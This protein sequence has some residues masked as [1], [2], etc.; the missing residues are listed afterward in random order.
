MEIFF[1]EIKRSP[2]EE[3]GSQYQF[4]GNISS[5]G[6][7]SV[8]KAIDINTKEEVAIKIINKSSHSI[9][10]LRIKEEINIL[11][12]LNHPNIL[13]FYDYIE[14]NVKVYI[15]ME[16]LKGGTLK[17]WINEHKNENISEETLSLIIKNILLAVSYLHNKNMC[18]R[19]IKPENI[20]FKDNSDINS[21]KLVD[22]GLSV[23][24]FDDYGEQTYCGTFIYMAPEQLENT[25]YSKIIDIWSIGIILYE[26]LNKGE[27]PFYIRGITKKNELIQ[28][29]KKHDLRCK[30]NVSIMG[31]NLIRKMLENQPT[32]RISANDALKHPW[33]TRN[34]LSPIP[35]NLYQKMFKVEIY[36]KSL[37]LVYIIVFLNYI[38]KKNKKNV[39]IIN[40]DYIQNVIKE[41]EIHKKNFFKRRLKEFKNFEDKKNDSPNFN[42]KIH[43]DEI[44]HFR[45]FNNKQR[46]NYSI[47]KTLN[48]YHINIMNLTSKHSFYNNSNSLKTKYYKK[49]VTKG[50]SKT[51][52]QLKMEKIPNKIA[53]KFLKNDLYDV[54]KRNSVKNLSLKKISS[55]SLPTIDNNQSYRNYPFSLNI[56]KLIL[57]K[58]KPLENNDKAKVSLFKLYNNNKNYF[59]N[60]K[61]NFKSSSFENFVNSK[62][63]TNDN[64]KNFEK[65]E[66]K[67]LSSSKLINHVNQKIETNN[68]LK[69][70]EKHK[71]FFFKKKK[72]KLI[73]N[74]NYKI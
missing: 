19:D 42:K 6:F 54:K 17:E 68:I 72:I 71:L 13:K 28:N 9:D 23:K 30:Y 3:I 50:G 73:N 39:Y 51:P 52:I 25:F 60:I 64:I 34:I 47:D 33:I 38:N 69:L 66:R 58:F 55:E 40:N 7:G 59:K 53:K 31:E 74:Q 27:H 37:H 56:K 8:V 4:I 41:N 46:I 20:M 24:N 5:G 21:L 57:P 65:L 49:L 22:F 43:Y 44:S 32:I 36:K 35:L 29:I 26:L 63:E 1:D 67:H 18:H 12:R 16:I 62:I 70:K 10:I 45:N 14:T 61:K 11:K 48:E 15:I 2:F